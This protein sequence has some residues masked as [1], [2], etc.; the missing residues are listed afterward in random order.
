MLK[1]SY[2]PYSNFRVG[3]ALKT[4][5]GKI[6]TGCNI[7]NISY[8]LSICAERVALFKAISNG[9][10]K[11]RAIAISSASSK[12][13]FPCGACLQFLAEFGPD[14]IVYIDKENNSAYKLS[15]LIPHFFN[16]KHNAQK[17]L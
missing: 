12:A 5:E 9:Y 8:G 11:F 3:A 17:S 4:I 15:K 10:T 6:F 14:L 2:C 7:E 16:N 1:Y 13:V